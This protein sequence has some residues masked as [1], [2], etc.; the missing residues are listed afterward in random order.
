MRVVAILQARMG[1][2][3]LPGKVM[4]PLAGK[5]MVQNI[6]ERVKRAERVDE[7]ILAIPE[8]DD[9]HFSSLPID[10]IYSY[11]G[12]ENDLVGRYLQVAEGNEADL[13]V[14]VPCD[15]PCVDPAYIDQ[16]VDEYFK[17]PY[18]FYSNTTGLVPYL[19][20]D[21]KCYY[22]IDGI[23]CEIFS[24]ST[25]KW[26]DVVT[27]G[28]AACREHPHKYW[29]DFSDEADCDQ[30]EW[31]IVIAESA[32]LRLDVNTLDDY[33]FIERIYTHFGHNRFTAQEILDCPPVRERLHG[34]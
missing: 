16:A 20:N 31:S 28:N 9:P 18:H 1:S 24:L 8:H 11:G 17:R 12:P 5:P 3:R 19:M 2:T 6:I 15:N 27:R 14:R 13:I 7:V 32:E 34:R 30:P 21:I 4:L 22:S 10:C 26:L 33:H 23:G 29:Y 25:M